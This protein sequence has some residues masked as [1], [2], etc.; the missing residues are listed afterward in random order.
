MMEE[1]IGRITRE[2]T[3]KGF[4]FHSFIG[5]PKFLEAIDYWLGENA[6]RGYQL[7]EAEQSFIL[8]EC[9]TLDEQSVLDYAKTSYGTTSWREWSVTNLS[10]IWDCKS[11][12]SVFT[13]PEKLR[14]LYL[15]RDS[16][17]SQ[18]ILTASKMFPQ[19]VFL[20]TY[21]ENS[22][23][24]LGWMGF[25]DGV[26]L[27]KYQIDDLEND[28]EKE[29][30]ET[31][32]MLMELDGGEGYPY[33]PISPVVDYLRPMFGTNGDSSPLPDDLPF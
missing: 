33:K 2:R 29:P 31:I 18:P 4:S 7:N 16:V 3:R 12:D 17:I 19:L 20:L 25:R 10:K 9:G 32:L 24:F 21:V 27:S 8:R 15:T 13:L 22:R 14:Y 26:V 23:D 6:I 11:Y 5:M 1:N 28:D 30:D